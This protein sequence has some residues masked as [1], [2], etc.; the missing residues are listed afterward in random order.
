[1]SV[2]VLYM[3][4]S[5]DGYITGPNDE[6]GNPGGDGFMRLHAWYGFEGQPP[7]TKGTG[8]GAQ[9][10]DEGNATCA[11]RQKETAALAM[12]IRAF[13]SHSWT[14]I[15]QAEVQTVVA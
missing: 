5:V 11:V 7:N 14:A 8:W 1:M 4:M 6:P 15:L 10:M 3:S 2:S 13:V 9:F 12:S